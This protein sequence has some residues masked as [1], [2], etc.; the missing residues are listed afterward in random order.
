MERRRAYHR[1]KYAKSRPGDRFLARALRARY[2]ASVTDLHDPILESA[3]VP[4]QRFAVPAAPNMPARR[5]WH[6]ESVPE[7][8]AG[9]KGKSLAAPIPGR[10]GSLPLGE[11][12]VEHVLPAWPPRS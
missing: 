8:V 9:W 12:E 7:K 10:R 6:P 1:P 2:P 11:A 3:G 5:R 4:Y